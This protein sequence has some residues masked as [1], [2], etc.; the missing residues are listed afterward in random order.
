MYRNLKKITLLASLLFCLKSVGQENELMIPSAVKDSLYIHEIENKNEVD[1]VLHAEPLFIDLI[2]DLGARKG[3]EEWNVGMG[4]TDKNKYDLYTALIEYEFAPIDRL[5]LEIELPFSFYYSANPFHSKKRSKL[6]GLKLAGQYS[7]YVSE[8]NKTSMAFGYIHETEFTE[9]QNYSKSKWITGTIYNPFFIV[10]KRF[11]NNY[12]T[13]LYTGPM[14]HQSYNQK[15]FATT[16]QINL[17]FHYM[18]S[19]TRNFIGLEVNKELENNKLNT[20]LRPQMRV[21][22]AENMMVGIVTGVPLQKEN[23]RLSSFI[24]LI[25]EPGHKV[26]N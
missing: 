6:N 5:G 10:A 11:G 19:G 21:G 12:H 20:I 17:N 13:L 15:P 2:R 25:Y 23:E 8:K 4:L 14:F 3:E 16:Y 26:I 18:I 7:F 9:F 1:K 24:R 22:I